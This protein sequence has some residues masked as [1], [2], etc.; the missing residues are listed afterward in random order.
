MIAGYS[1]PC[2]LGPVTTSMRH[3]L[4]NDGELAG[5]SGISMKHASFWLVID[6]RRNTLFSADP[7]GFLEGVR[8]LFIETLC[9]VRSGTNTMFPKKHLRAV[10]LNTPSSL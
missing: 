10:D 2:H 5:P 9:E 7:A 6:S 1:K 4:V 3:P 8:T